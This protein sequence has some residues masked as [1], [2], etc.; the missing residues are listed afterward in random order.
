MVV[1]KRTKGYKAK[2]AQEKL[3]ADSVKIA[4][5]IEPLIKEEVQKPETDLA[6]V[7]PWCITQGKPGDKFDNLGKLQCLGC[8][9]TWRRES[10]GKPY[11]LELER[12]Q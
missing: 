12:S 1:D 5:P 6:Q 4:P 9:K 3:E 10:L 7:C 2:V 8:G 11:S